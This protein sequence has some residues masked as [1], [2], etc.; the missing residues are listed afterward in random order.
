MEVSYQDI[1]F[2]LTIESLF[3]TNVTYHA[4]LETVKKRGRGR[5]KRSG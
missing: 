2:I 1:N 3:E 5:P 4:D